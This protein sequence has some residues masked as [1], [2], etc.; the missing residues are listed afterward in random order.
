[1]KYV[2]TIITLTLMAFT[3]SLNVSAQNGPNA[4]YAEGSVLVK[5]KPGTPGC[6]AP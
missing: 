6:Q 3:L 4:E 2:L 5:F 1:M